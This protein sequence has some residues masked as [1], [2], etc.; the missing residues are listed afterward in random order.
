M[1]EDMYLYDIA[2]SMADEVDL[3]LSQYR[4][5]AGITVDRSRLLESVPAW[6]WI[7]FAGQLVAQGVPCFG[8]FG[9]GTGALVWP[10]FG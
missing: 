5:M 3:A 7:R 2:P 8:G 1:F 6:I 4:Y 10:N 9:D